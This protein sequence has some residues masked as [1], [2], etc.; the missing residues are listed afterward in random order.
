MKI[1]LSRNQLKYIAIIAMVIDHIGAFFIPSSTIIYSIFR[2]IGKLTAPLMCYFL[3]EGYNYTSSKNKYLV[4]LGIF[5]IIS[6]FAFSLAISN[7]LFIPTFNMIFTLFICFLVLLSY[8]KIKNKLVKWIVILSFILISDFS[9]W[10]IFAPCWVLLF[11]IFKDK[12]SLQICFYYIVTCL[13]IIIKYIIINI[14][15]WDLMLRYSG[16]LLFIPIVCLY[17]G[18]KGK[19]GKFNKWFFYI[20]YPVHLIIIALIRF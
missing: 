3:V 16:L 20:F 9:D 15:G 17:N 18:E 4:R 14:S 7:K 2:F 11:Y 8:E 12:R 13:V 5:S 10:G 19:S 1:G 6:Q